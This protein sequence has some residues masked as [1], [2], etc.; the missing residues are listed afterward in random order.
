MKQRVPCD[1]RGVFRNRELQSDVWW[2]AVQERIEHLASERQRSS[3]LFLGG[4]FRVTW[5]PKSPGILGEFRRSPEQGFECRIDHGARFPDFD[6]IMGLAIDPSMPG[7][8]PPSSPFRRPAAYGT[9]CRRLGVGRHPVQTFQ[10]ASRSRPSRTRHGSL[11]RGLD[12]AAWSSL[13]SRMTVA[14]NDAAR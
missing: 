13:P 8:K 14:G 3:G 7:E 10:R 12:H 2:Q 1:R 5:I 6:K 4:F 9:R 11:R